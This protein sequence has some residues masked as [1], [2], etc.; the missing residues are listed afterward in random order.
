[1][2]KIY[3]NYDNH[4]VKATMVYANEDNK[5]Y[6]DPEF[7]KPVLHEKGDVYALFVN[8]V[9][10]SDITGLCKPTQMLPEGVLVYDGTR[11]PAVDVDYVG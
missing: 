7:T 6:F 2:S 9:I 8:G 5:L 3:S 10:I 4:H 1:M 11:F